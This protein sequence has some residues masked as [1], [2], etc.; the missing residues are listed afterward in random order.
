MCAGKA[1]PVRIEIIA[2]LLNKSR[3]ICFQ[4]TMCKVDKFMDSVYYTF[5][6]GR[7]GFCILLP[8]CQ[9]R[10]ISDH[11]RHVQL[12]QIREG[13]LPINHVLPWW[14]LAQASRP[15]PDDRVYSQGMLLLVA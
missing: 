11:S 6:L 14:F 8:Q 15:L 7:F 5:S 3:E 10:N 4:H 1:K 13:F 12:N 9:L 2:T